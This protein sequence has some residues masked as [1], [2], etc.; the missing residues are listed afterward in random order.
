[1]RVYLS[2]HK[3]VPVKTLADARRAVQDYIGNRVV[4]WR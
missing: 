3:S 1:M 4:S 2:D